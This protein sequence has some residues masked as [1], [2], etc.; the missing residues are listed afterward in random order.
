MIY[1]GPLSVL[2]DQHVI[3]ILL[4]VAGH[5]RCTKSDVYRNIGHHSNMPKKLEILADSGL[6]ELDSKGNGR[7]TLI[8]L[9]DIGI[10]VV[11]MLHRIESMLSRQ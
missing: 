5:E 11:E 3:P 4:Y 6:I 7:T 10:R 9:T 1:D 8:I 2:C